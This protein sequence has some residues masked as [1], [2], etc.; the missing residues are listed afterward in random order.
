MTHSVKLAVEGMTCNG[1][2]RSV[3][4]AVTRVVG[5]TKVD[6]SLASSSA[7]V[8]FDAASASPK[9]I[10]EAIEGAGFEAR[11]AG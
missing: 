7:T 10:V 8:E 1:C 4:N 11:V 2:V 5:V 9:V 3:T 6:V